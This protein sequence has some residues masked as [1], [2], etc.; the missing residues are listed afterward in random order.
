[1]KARHRQ[2]KPS[3]DPWEAH[4]RR[5]HMDFDF[6]IKEGVMDYV[7]VPEG[8]YLCEITEVRVGTSRAGDERWSM[9]LVVVE[10][11]Y[12]QR[13]AAWDSLVFSTRG[14]AAGTF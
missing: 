12:T 7:S 1:M 8:T 10:G 3:T 9:R 6:D 14:Q 5:N 13:H 11:E 4:P 2:L